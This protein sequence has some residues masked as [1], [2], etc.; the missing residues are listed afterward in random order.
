MITSQQSEYAVISKANKMSKPL[1][2]NQQIAIVSPQD[3]VEVAERK[4]ELDIAAVNVSK[5]V[6]DKPLKFSQSPVHIYDEVPKSLKYQSN[7][8]DQRPIKSAIIIVDNQR[9]PSPEYAVVESTK[10]DPLVESQE[11]EDQ[12]Y[13]LA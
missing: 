4:D 12:H 8:E 11:E 6:D 2:D 5:L 13:Y 1:N 7:M 3:Y 9:S 10:S